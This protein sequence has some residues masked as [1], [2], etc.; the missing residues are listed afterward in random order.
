M[1]LPVVRRSKTMALFNF[2]RRDKGKEVFQEQAD[3]QAKAQAIRDEIQRL[4][5]PGQITVDVEGSKVKVGG[6]VPDQA[7]HDKLM[8][9]IGNI[10]HIDAVDDS[11]LTGTQANPKPRVHEVQSGETL[12]AIAKK[13]YGDA[14]AFNRIF[15][16]N[17]PMIKDANQIYPGQVLLIPD[18]ET[19]PA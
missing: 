14:N 9:I 11:G 13:H 2:F 19:A 16:A 12:S 17:R 10:R 1:T 6:N 8:M 7:T 18:A 5:L 15:E 3:A 4:G